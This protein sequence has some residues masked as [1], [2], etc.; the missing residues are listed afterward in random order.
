MSKFSKTHP[1]FT[2]VKNSFHIFRIN[3]LTLRKNVSIFI[4]NLTKKLIIKT[5]RLHFILTKEGK[6][7][8]KLI[9]IFNIFIILFFIKISQYR[10]NSFIIS[11]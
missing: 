4:S 8:S 7:L 2:R 3:F 6:N 1:N 11:F 5:Q 9:F 10:T